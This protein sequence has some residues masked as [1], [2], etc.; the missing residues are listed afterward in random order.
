MTAAQDTG[1]DLGMA[2]AVL[3]EVVALLE[4]FAATGASAAIDLGGLPFSR[5]DRDELDAIL[6]RG[7]V[8]ATVDLAGRSEIWETAFSGVWRVRHFG[9]SEI[10]VDLIE[11]TSCPEILR[12][13]RRDARLAA[14]K[15]AARLAERRLAQARELGKTAIAENAHEE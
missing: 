1:C 3:R 6:G 5:R 14:P 15:L 12:S 4:T 11:I 13:D 10:A 9:K 2:E 7:E 8:A